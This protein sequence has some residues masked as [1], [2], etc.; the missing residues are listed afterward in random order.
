LSFETLW[1]STT[2]VARKGYGDHAQEQEDLD[3][4]RPIACPTSLTAL[5]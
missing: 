2:T 3:I 5:E 4:T 1:S